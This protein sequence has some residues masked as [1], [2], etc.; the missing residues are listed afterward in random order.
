M[1]ILIV[2]KAKKI[3]IFYNSKVFYLKNLD[4]LK[5]Y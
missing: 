2:I 5:I 4:K 1:N 3:K